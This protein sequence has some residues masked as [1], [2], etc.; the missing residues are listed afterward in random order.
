MEFK[1]QVDSQKNGYSLPA[2]VA[3]ESVYGVLWGQGLCHL[4]YT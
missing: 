3:Y 1:F 2:S 4:L